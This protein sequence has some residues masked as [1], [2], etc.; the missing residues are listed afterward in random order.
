MRALVTI[1]STSKED[2]VKI[3]EISLDNGFNVWRG[4]RKKWHWTRF[5]YLYELKVYK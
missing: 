1:T 2:A 5:K 3:R 4:I